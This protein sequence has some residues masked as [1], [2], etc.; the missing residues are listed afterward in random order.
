M[1]GTITIRTLLGQAIDVFKEY[2]ETRGNM[3]YSLEVYMQEILVYIEYL[4]D[5]NNN[6]ETQQKDFINYLEDE[7]KTLEK[8]ILETIDDMDKY[9]KEVKSLIIE[10]ILQKYKSIIG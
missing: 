8:D 7:I 4:E 3:D 9:M 1:K 10:E 6:L 5:K 2:I